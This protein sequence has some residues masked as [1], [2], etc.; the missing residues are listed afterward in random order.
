M[1]VLE[2]QVQEEGPLARVGGMIADEAGGVVGK[3]VGGVL[4]LL[5]TIQITYDIL[6]CFLIS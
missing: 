3:E 6:T 4:P 5:R 1:R 2:G